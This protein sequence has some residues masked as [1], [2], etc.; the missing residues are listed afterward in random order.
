MIAYEQDESADQA[1]AQFDNR[2]VDG[3]ICRVK[4]FIS[5]KDGETSTRRD[6]GLLARRLYLMNI[7]YD[8]S[9]QELEQMVSTFVPVER[10]VVPRDRAGLARGYAFVYLRNASDIPKA[11]DYVDGR[12]LRSR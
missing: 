11:I 10:A 3:L 4:P 9:V 5:K 12:H 8:A 2:A 7:P 6:E 1:I